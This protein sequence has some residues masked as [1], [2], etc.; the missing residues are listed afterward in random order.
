MLRTGT[1]VQS[2]LTHASRKSCVDCECELTLMAH[3]DYLEKAR[4]HMMDAMGCLELALYWTAYWRNHH[5]LTWNRLPEG[6]RCSGARIEDA[7]EFVMEAEK[8]L[9][10]LRL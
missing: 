1:E 7:L 5:I 6:S 4:E 2:E 9:K 3:M 8:A 10:Q